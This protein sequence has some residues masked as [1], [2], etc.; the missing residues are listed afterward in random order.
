MS[1]R[2]ERPI[3]GL[4]LFVEQRLNI[5][6]FINVLFR[7]DTQVCVNLIPLSRVAASSPFL[8]SGSHFFFNFGFILLSTSPVYILYSVVYKFLLF[9][10]L[11]YCVAP[12]IF[13]ASI[14]SG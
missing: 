5:Q 2:E 14:V 13:H 4:H 1:A 10:D 12:K 8:Y 11:F 9:E 7:Y 6:D 3:D